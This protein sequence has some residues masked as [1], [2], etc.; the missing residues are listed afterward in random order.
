MKHV[1]LD[2][3]TLGHGPDAVIVAIGAVLFDFENDSV[4]DSWYTIIDPVSCVGYKLT[5]TP[6]TVC[7]WLQQSDEAR[8]IF[9]STSK[10]DLRMALR[11]FSAWIKE[12]DPVGV[13]GNGA[14]FDNVIINS[15]YMAI[16]EPLPWKFYQNRCFRTMKSLF[17][18]QLE[19]F[20]VHHNAV[21]DA[22]YQ[23]AVLKKINRV[24]NLGL[25]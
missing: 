16:K 25:K 1:M 20:G 21:D 22:A 19:R 7:W 17:K 10:L 15:S 2:L 3:E 9:S 11:L 23:V 13:W 14:D 4:N 5:M 12:H 24:H 18:V 8:K 6:E